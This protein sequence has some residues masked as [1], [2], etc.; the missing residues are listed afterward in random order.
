MVYKKE[1]QHR[2]IGGERTFMSDEMAA[3]TDVSEKTWMDLIESGKLKGEKFEPKTKYEECYDDIAGSII[4][5]HG[6]KGALKY[7]TPT[8]PRYFVKESDFFNYANSKGLTIK[9]KATVKR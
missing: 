5:T 3:L 8:A 6:K 7:L 4:E 2:I 1:K 9:E